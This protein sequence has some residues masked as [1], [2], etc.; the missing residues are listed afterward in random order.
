MESAISF[1]MQRPA[2]FINFA[3]RGGAGQPVFLRCRALQG[4]H[5]WLTPINMINKGGRQKKWEKAVRLT[6][7]VDPSFFMPSL[8]LKQ[9]RGYRMVCEEVLISEQPKLSLISSVP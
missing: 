4:E 2:D 7:W 5:P 9:E 1:G 8:S 6:S 3:W